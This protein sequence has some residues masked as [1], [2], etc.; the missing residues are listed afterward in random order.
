MPSLMGWIFQ[1]IIF[2]FPIFKLAFSDQANVL[3]EEGTT[4]GLTVTMN[5]SSRVIKYAR[6][7]KVSSKPGT[8]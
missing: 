3:N 1:V 5:T 8:V 7:Q 4:R 2:H 6:A